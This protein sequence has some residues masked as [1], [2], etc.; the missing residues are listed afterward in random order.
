M[1]LGIV[2]HRIESAAEKAKHS[3]L[4]SLQK[5]KAFS[6]IHQGVCRLQ[7]T[8]FPDFREFCM[9]MEAQALS[10]YSDRSKLIARYVARLLAA[11]SITLLNSTMTL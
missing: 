8:N 11:D 2:G 6:H 4:H 1:D 3:F 7:G 5:V 9:G 10:F